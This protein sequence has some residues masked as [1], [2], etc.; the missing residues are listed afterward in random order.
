VQAM[1][2]GVSL[3]TWSS[4][5]F[6]YAE[7]YDES[8]GRYRGLRAGQVVSLSADN[9]GLIVKPDVARRQMDAEV[10]AIVQPNEPPAEPPPGS[11]PRSVPTPTAP[12]KLHRF[13]GT[14]TLDSTRVG[15]DA[16]RIAD[17][18]IAHLVVEPDARVV[19]TLEIEAELPA[20]APDQLIRVVTENGRV[21]KFTSQG[22]EK[23]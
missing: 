22:F 17:E 6:A 12:T 19:V 20:G 13:H 9:A 3:L 16:S 2:D 8:A 4:D 5:S 15:R 14:V 7:S 23:E 11:G 18:I 10:A 21:L 1:R